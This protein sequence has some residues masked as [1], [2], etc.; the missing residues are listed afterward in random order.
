MS[1]IPPKDISEIAAQGH[2]VAK[3]IKTTAKDFVPSDEAKKAKEEKPLLEVLSASLLTSEELRTKKVPSAP[4]MLGGWLREGDYGIV[5]AP[6]GVGKT[7]FALG[8]AHAISAGESFGP[9]DAGEKAR[10]LYVDGEMPLD[11]MQIRDRGLTRG[12]DMIYLHHEE[13]FHSSNRCLNLADY[14]TR[15]AIT[16]LI[17]AQNR[18][19]IFLD[20]LSTLVSGVKENDSLEWEGLSNWFLEL[21]RRHITLILVH[22]AGRNGEMRGTSKREDMAAWIVRLTSDQPAVK[23]ARFLSHFSKMPRVMA[24]GLEDYQW[25]FNTEDS[26]EV[27]IGWERAEGKDRFRSFIEDGV[28]NCADLAELLGVSRGRVS[29]M[30]AAGVKAGWLEK[31]GRDY[32]IRKGPSYSLNKEG[33][34]KDPHIE[35]EDGSFSRV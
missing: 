13:L 6:R 35:N 9:W 10:V 25:H 11:L 23:G 32:A 34:P 21:R 22:H 20:N 2:D 14:D 5:Y 33:K 7:W 19:V 30:A 8:L 15:Q 26:Q 18:N 1:S 12:G 27:S 3:V 28:G 29:Q 24:D 31:K 4:V 17:L 16:E